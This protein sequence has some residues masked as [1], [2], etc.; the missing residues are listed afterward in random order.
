MQLQKRKT[1]SYQKTRF[2]HLLQQK[3]TSEEQLEE[4]CRDCGFVCARD[5][6]YL[7]MEIRFE[8]ETAQL[9]PC[10]T[11]LEKY[12]GD[13]TDFFITGSDA[14]VGDRYCGACMSGKTAA[15]DST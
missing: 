10:R 6:N 9:E 13:S 4:I 14:G 3:N 5:E 7:C 8:N 15:G 1:I 11:L 2:L 12:L